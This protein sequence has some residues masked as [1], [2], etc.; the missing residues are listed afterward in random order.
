MASRSDAFLRNKWGLS[1]IP[2]IAN[3]AA[4]I[5]PPYLLGLAKRCGLGEGIKD[6]I[7]EID[8]VRH[9]PPNSSHS[10]NFFPSHLSSLQ[11]A[12]APTRAG[13]RRT[14]MMAEAREGRQGSQQELWDELNPGTPDDDGELEELF[15]GPS[16]HAFRSPPSVFHSLFFLGKKCAICDTLLL[17]GSTLALR[18]DETS[19]INECYFCDTYVHYGCRSRCTAPCPRTDYKGAK[20]KSLSEEAGRGSSSLAAPS[21]SPLSPPVSSPSAP[22]ATKSAPVDV[23]GSLKEY[24]SALSLA[25]KKSAITFRKPKEDEEEVREREREREC[26]RES[27]EERKAQAGRE[28]RSDEAL[29]FSRLLI[30]ANTALADGDL[31][32]RP[33]GRRRR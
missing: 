15:C 5:F 8:S 22:Q 28:E 16:G 2:C 25:M 27:G 7:K 33:L 6:L 10:T 30:V 32:L 24:S 19:M 21:L 18:G 26:V 3:K 4:Y 29:H 14:H 31:P 11:P 12:P 23:F 17:S 1:Q 20:R 9:S 13:R